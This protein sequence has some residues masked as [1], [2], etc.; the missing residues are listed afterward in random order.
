MGSCTVSS[1]GPRLGAGVRVTGCGFWG[2]ALVFR[3]EGGVHPGVYV[4]DEGGSPR[5][6][7]LDHAGAVHVF[8]VAAGRLLAV[9]R[10]RPGSIP[11]I[12]DE[13][14]FLAEGR[15]VLRVPG[16]SLG[17]S[18][19]GRRAAVVDVVRGVL[20]AVDLLA[21][22]SREACPVATAMHPMLAPVPALSDDGA[23]ALVMTARTAQLDGALEAISLDDG[24]RRTVLGPLSAPSR[25][26]G[27]FLPSGRVVALVQ[28]LHDGPRCTLRVLEADGPGR[29]VHQRAVNQ[30][31]SVPA[32]LD[33][34][35]VV[36]A[37]MVANAPGETSGPLHA[38]RVGLDD[39]NVV[40]LAELGVAQP[41]LRRGDG[42]VLVEG[43]ATA[44]VLRVA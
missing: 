23:R 42:G 24:E 32:V 21:A 16:Q 34:R 40:P 6:V 43:L 12:V 17:V 28:E 4:E 41:R 35:T 33:E 15:E 25:V 10:F 30:G 26:S 19:D 11:P 39:G 20:H 8:P 36:A 7:W 44:L 27:G 3:A 38:C 29:V 22:T 37:L 31:V 18:A 2:S 1:R 9:H 14:A 5:P 13:V